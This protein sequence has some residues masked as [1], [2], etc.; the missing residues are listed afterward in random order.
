MQGTHVFF[1]K[2][3]G[4]GCQG[5]VIHFDP[6]KGQVIVQ[7][8]QGSEWIGRAEQVFKDDAKVLHR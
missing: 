8:E 5:M 2:G 7:D 6:V 1:F 3:N 4:E